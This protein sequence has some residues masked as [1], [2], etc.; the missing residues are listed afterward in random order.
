[1]CWPGGLGGFTMG[2]SGARE[3]FERPARWN[4]EV[5]RCFCFCPWVCPLSERS[6][7]AE[8]KRR[9]GAEVSGGHRP[10]R[11]LLSCSPWAPTCLSAPHAER[12]EALST[13]R[14]WVL[15]SVLWDPL[16][17]IFVLQESWGEAGADQG[18]GSKFSVKE[19]RGC[20]YSQFTAASTFGCE[21]AFRLCLCKCPISRPDHLP[22]VCSWVSGEPGD[23]G[24]V[25]LGRLASQPLHVDKTPADLVQRGQ[26][27][28]RL[29]E[30]NMDSVICGYIYLKK[31]FLFP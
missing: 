20:L 18:R 27:A 26:N 25:P 16:A 8:A 28:K 17:A 4:L 29:L 13:V 5:N 9:K 31:P 10:P 30:L 19:L 21:H 24:R 6:Q 11:V 15:L 12:P 14:V 22:P 2:L 3:G 7:E 1:M 23:P